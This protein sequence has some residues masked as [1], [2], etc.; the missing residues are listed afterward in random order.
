MS[1]QII[2]NTGLILL[3]IHELDAIRCK[4]WR[5][6]PGLSL[7]S[8]K[9]GQLVFILAHIPILYGLFQQLTHEIFQI[10][11]NVFLIV[12]LILH[13]IY[14]RHRNNLF[15]HWF[16]WFIISGASICGLLYIMLKWN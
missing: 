3:I 5:I 12:H 11:F 13:L 10:G 2:L 1:E 6:I 15:T 9:T 4:E 14:T 7:L 8:D 16:S